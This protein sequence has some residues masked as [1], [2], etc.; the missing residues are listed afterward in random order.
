MSLISG[1]YSSIPPTELVIRSL[2]SYRKQKRKLRKLAK[3]SFHAVPSNTYLQYIQSDAWASKRRM[4]LARRGRKCEDCGSCERLEIHHLTYARLGMEKPEDLRVLCRKCH[5][6][7]HAKT[8]SS[9]RNAAEPEARGR[10]A[11]TL[12]GK[13]AMRAI[14]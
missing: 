10:R 4:I 12:A 6:R 11:V 13:A 9:R 1:I 14:T 5:E 2:K 3:K 8:I 7:R